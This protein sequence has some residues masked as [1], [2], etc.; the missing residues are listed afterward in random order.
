[1]SFRDLIAYARFARGLPDLLRRRV[2]LAEAQTIVRDRL[3]RREE[4]FLAIARRSFFGPR[5]TPYHELLRLARCEWGDLEREVRADGVEG[6]LE[7]LRRSG[8][9]V[10][11]E[12]FK[13]RTPIV[14]AGREIPTSPHAFD[15]PHLTAHL[16][17]R[18]GGSTGVPARLAIDLDRI[19]ESVPTRMVIFATHGIHDWPMLRWA[20]SFPSLGISGMLGAI[21]A[22]NPPRRWFTPFT[23]A[24][25]RHG[26][27]ERLAIAVIRRAARRVG[28]AL[29]EPELVPLD[30]AATVARAV[31]EMVDREGRCVLHA[32]L[33]LLVR[34]AL[35][36]REEGIDLTGAVLRGSAEP[37]TPAKVEAIRS[38]GARYVSGY[39][40]SEGG[41][42][43]AACHRPLDEN[44]Q[45]FMADG[46]ALI[47]HPRE[48][49]EF[50]VTVDAFCFT[51]LR[52][53]NPKLMLNVQSDDFGI[54]EERDCGCPF[55]AMGLTRH[56][57]HIR[58][59]RKLTS[60]G[61]TLIG[62]DMVRILDQV[63]PAR[64]GGGPLDYQ[65]VEEERDGKTR[66]SLFVHP[67]LAIADPEAVRRTVL[68]GLA[69][70]GGAATLASAMWT[71]SRALEIRREP[72]R[73]SG[74]GKF[75]PL[76]SFGLQGRGQ[77]PP[78]ARSAAAT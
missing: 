76:W 43:G 36:A 73:V 12:E 20:P 15:N 14:R 3:A 45:H 69:S 2:T 58:S 9:Y 77:R 32:Y 39:A 42:A 10:T 11:F 19:L 17:G 71:Q 31:R 78:A 8:V 61:M 23:A 66:L 7:T 1:L 68:E 34:V 16:H 72:P 41:Q 40:F 4:N 35:A 46:L 6:A 13:A 37:P 30:Q 26:P 54:I 64:F 27:R 47:Q 56:L 38:S 49:P 24:E 59:F 63:L 74:S 18:T 51:S 33:S 29:P 75:S 25:L 48:L 5:R 60:D 50:G 28:A 44:D 67:R 70:K 65:L 55:H 62:T 52:A 57:R 21:V 53:S 22:G